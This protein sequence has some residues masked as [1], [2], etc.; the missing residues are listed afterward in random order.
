MKIALAYN[1][2]SPPPTHHSR[3][4]SDWNLEFD[5][6]ET[7]E[8]VA[9]ALSRLGEVVLIEA[10]PGCRREFEHHRPELVFNIA[11]GFEGPERE[12]EIPLLLEEL[13]IPYT[14]SGPET[15][16]LCLDKHRTAVFL[17]ERGVAV[18]WGEAFP[19]GD[20]VEW[21]GPFPAIVKP[22]REGSSK[23]IRDD[24]LV[25]DM[26][27]LAKKVSLISRRYRQPALVEEFLEGREFT[28]ALV[29]NDGDLEVLPP[30]EID[31]KA[32]PAGAQPIYSYEAK[33]VWDRPESPLPI[34]LCPAQVE[35]ELERELKGTAEQAFRLTGC[36]DWA[37]IDL[38]LD[39]EGNPR[40]LE[41]NPL[42]GIL[43]RPEENSC[44]PKAARAAG[45]SYEELIVRVVVA[46]RTRYRI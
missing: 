11:E 25:R 29:G 21:P 36:R 17:S 2:K 12:A 26:K 9:R 43:P 3:S 20:K 8:A 18:P 33:W 15:L 34:F 13:G 6:R 23:G 27:A 45:L 14:G 39:K 19:P 37:R 7:I 41:I 31:H 40:I 10:L 38:R 1:S 4:G 22:L 44:F 46:A 24:C 16:L 28:I 32:L 5:D 35:P 42:P 30:V